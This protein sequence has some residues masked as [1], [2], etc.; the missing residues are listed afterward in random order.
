MTS[1]NFLL[2]P[3]VCVCVCVCVCVY[4]CVRAHA[5]VHLAMYIGNPVSCGVTFHLFVMPCL[6]KM[7]GW[8]HPHHD[9][10][11]VKVTGLYSSTIF[12]PP[13]YLVEFSRFPGPKTRVSKGHVKM[14]G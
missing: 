13:M 14:E 8:K 2:Y 12:L 1:I 5:C 4:V 6:W 10:I 7:S 3:P 11:T 9:E